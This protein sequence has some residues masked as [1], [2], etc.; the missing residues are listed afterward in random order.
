MNILK[1]YFELTLLFI[2]RL[3]SKF[4]YSPNNALLVEEA[5]NAF[6]SKC[7]QHGKAVLNRATFGRRLP[8]AFPSCKKKKRRS[9]STVFFSKFTRLASSLRDSLAKLRLTDAPA[10]IHTQR[11]VVIT[12]ISKYCNDGGSPKRII[13]KWK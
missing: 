5:Y 13:H 9:C 7:Q 2:F 6:I 11:D 10:F 8:S 1:Q 4:C 3:I 12:I